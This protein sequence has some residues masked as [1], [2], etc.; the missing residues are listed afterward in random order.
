[1]ENIFGYPDEADLTS[2]LGQSHVVSDVHNEFFDVS[3]QAHR[4]DIAL[5]ARV[6]VGFGVHRLGKETQVRLHGLLCTHKLYDFNYIQ[7][8]DCSLILEYNNFR[9]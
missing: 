8:R 3:S 4:A 1:M 7:P 9:V 2:T 6:P 5:S